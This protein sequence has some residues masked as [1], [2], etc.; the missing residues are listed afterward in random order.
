MNE[1]LQSS[2]G[3]RTADEILTVDEE[4]RVHPCQC[5][6]CCVVRTAINHGIFQVLSG[7]DSSW[8]EVVESAVVWGKTHKLI[9]NE[10]EAE[11]FRVIVIRALHDQALFFENLTFQPPEQNK[12][13]NEK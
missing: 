12:D 1:K 2:G 7:G 13:Q 8:F 3:G 4:G 10:R 11:L 9:N 5:A 6:S